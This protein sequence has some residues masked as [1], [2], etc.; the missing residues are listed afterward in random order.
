MLGIDVKGKVTKLEGSLG[1]IENMLGT[2]REKRRKT[3]T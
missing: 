1:K 2:D 3:V